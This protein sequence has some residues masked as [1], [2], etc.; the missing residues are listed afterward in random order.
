MAP[1]ICYLALAAALG[2]FEGTST[3]TGRFL[4]T[5][6]NDDYGANS[7]IYAY[8]DRDIVII[9]LT[10]GGQKDDDTSY[11]RAALAAIERAIW[12]APMRVG[13]HTN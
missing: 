1:A 11:S 13:R 7:L 2:W 12:P 5:R 3:A 8:L 6:G 10:H 4:F 9:I